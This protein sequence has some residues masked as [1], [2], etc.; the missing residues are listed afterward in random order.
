MFFG[1][2]EFRSLGLVLQP[3]LK[4]AFVDDALPEEVMK[5]GIAI[6]V[7]RWGDA[8]KTLTLLRQAGELANDC[9]LAAVTQACLG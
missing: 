1:P 3:R 5:T 9:G 8:R 4:T 7:N 2:Y 6:A